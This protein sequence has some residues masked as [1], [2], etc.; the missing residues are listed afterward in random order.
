MGSQADNHTESPGL[1]YEF[2][3]NTS[4]DLVTEPCLPFPT[5]LTSDLRIS[6]VLGRS[7]LI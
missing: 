1:G 2:R 3:D 5:V 6:V 4:L 7:S